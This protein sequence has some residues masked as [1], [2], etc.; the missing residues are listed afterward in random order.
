MNIETASNQDALD[1][2]IAKWRQRWPEWSLAEVF[3]PAGQRATVLAWAALLQELGD[4]AWGGRDPRPGEAKLAWWAEELG[5]W[6]RGARRHPLGIDLQRLPAGWDTLA[7]ALPALQASRERPGDHAEAFALLEPFATAAAEVELRLFGAGLDRAQD[8]A[9]GAVRASRDAIAACLLQARFFHEGDG[10]VPL[11]IFA[12]AGEG[13]PTAIWAGQL[14][15]RW[16]MA[17]AATLPRRL[18]TALARARLGLAEPGRALKPW[19]VLAKAW[20]AAR[21]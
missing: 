18:W 3:V 16:P 9:P 10:H 11:A 2:F 20:R 8:P 6:S 7:A 17:P 21:N 13:E 12:R 4:A 14:R 15:Q 5:G 1:S 19:A